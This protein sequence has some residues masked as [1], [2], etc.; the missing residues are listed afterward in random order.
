MDPLLLLVTTRVTDPALALRTIQVDRV[1][2]ADQATT[3]ADQATTT[4]D[5]ATAMVGA[6]LVALQVTSPTA[7]P[8]LLF[9]ATNPRQ[10]TVGAMENAKVLATAAP[11][12]RSI[13]VM[14]G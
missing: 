13:A 8:N 7:V 14:P 10:A 2:R 1:D 4:A 3:M 12:L 11:I 6:Q 9:A 5:Q